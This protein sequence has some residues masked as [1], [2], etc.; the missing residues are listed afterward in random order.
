MLPV[1]SGQLI[2][3]AIAATGATATLLG[4]KRD[5][6]DILARGFRTV[7]CGYVIQHGSFAM[8]TLRNFVLDVATHHHALFTALM[9]RC[10][11]F[12]IEVGEAGIGSRLLGCIERIENFVA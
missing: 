6:S 3:A 4:I 10:G 1:G 7:E 8:N 5:K 11:R 2:V 12:H 9:K